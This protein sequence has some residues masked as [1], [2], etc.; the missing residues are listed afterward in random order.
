MLNKPASR[1]A[2]RLELLLVKPPSVVGVL[3]ALV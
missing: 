3:N 1:A 2:A